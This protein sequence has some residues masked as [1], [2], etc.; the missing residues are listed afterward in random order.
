ML[1]CLGVF[2]MWSSPRITC[3]IASSMSSTGDAKLYV[4][5]PSER[6]S[7]T[8][9][10]FSFGTSM[11][12][13]PRPPSRSRRRRAS[14]TGSRPR[15]RTRARRRAAGRQLA[16]S[17]HR[18]ELEGRAVRPSRSRSRSS[19]RWICSIDSATSRL[20]S[21]FSIRNRHSPS[22]PRANSQL[23]RNVWTPPI[24]RKPVGL[25]AMR[26]RTTSSRCYVGC[27]RESARTAPTTPP[28]CRGSRAASRAR[29]RT[30]A[31]A[32]ATTPIASA[33]GPTTA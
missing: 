8:S 28:G 6:T 1:I 4:A 31:R 27:V 22:R 7:T 26:T 32:S 11:H 12:R 20:V 19:D 14:G 17:F 16:A 33:S 21:V 3:V 2:E 30:P 25:G 5:R 15:P 23:K 13:E 9:S 18:V 10:S 24:W 29:S